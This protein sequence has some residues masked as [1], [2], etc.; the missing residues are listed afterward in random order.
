MPDLKG[1]AKR[2]VLPLFE[3]RDLTVIFRGEGFVVAQDP[4]PGTPVVEGM[5]ITLEFR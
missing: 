3:R 4:A 1:M 5:T 2:T